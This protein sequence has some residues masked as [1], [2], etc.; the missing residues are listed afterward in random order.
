MWLRLALDRILVIFAFTF[1]SARITGMC[2][3]PDQDVCSD[4]DL[5]SLAAVIF[6]LEKAP[7]RGSVVCA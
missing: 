3:H 1:Q 5:G 7:R 2:H 6:L 4:L